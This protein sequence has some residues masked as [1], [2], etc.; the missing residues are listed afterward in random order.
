MTLRLPQAKSHPQETLRFHRC[1]IL[2]QQGQLTQ[3]RMGSEAE[4]LCRK[5]RQARQCHRGLGAEKKPRRGE[6]LEN[7]DPLLGRKSVAALSR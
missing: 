2:Q 7:L 4:T 3:R 5:Q 1:G 6:Q